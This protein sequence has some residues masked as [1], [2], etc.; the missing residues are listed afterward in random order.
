[1]RRL[2]QIS[3]SYFIRL[4]LLTLLAIAFDSQIS[5]GQSEMPEFTGERLTFSGVDSAAWQSLPPVIAELEQSGQ[6]TY[7][8]VVVESSGSGPTATKDYTDRLYEQWLQQAARNNVAFDTQR[9]VLVVLAI[10]NRQISVKAGQTLLQDYGLNGVVIDQ[11]LVQPYFISMAKAGNYPEGVKSL[12]K[13]LNRRIVARDQPSAPPTVV[14]QSLPVTITPPAPAALNA[15]PS[16]AA[17][18]EAQQ[19]TNESPPSFLRHAVTS[20]AYIAGT[21]IALGLLTLVILRIMHLQARKPLEVKRSNFRQH[22]VQLSDDIDLL[23]E[24]H[25]KLPFTDKDYTEPMIGETLS[26]YDGIQTSLETL[27]QRWLELMDVW[28]KIDALEKQEHFFGR[29]A[30]LEATKLLDTVPVGD[31]ENSLNEQCVKTLDRLEDAHEQ[32]Q[33]LDKSLD[34]DLVRIQE[35]L[36]ELQLVRL[37][38]EPYQ[39]SLEKVAELR[40]LAAKITVPDPIGSQTIQTNARET[41][42]SVGSLTERILQHRRGIDELHGKLNTVIVRLASLRNA[43]MKFCEEG[44][45]PSPLFPTIQHHCEECL[46]LLNLADANTAAEHLKQGFELAAQSQSAI[47]LQVDSQEFCRREIP[48][49]TNEQRQLESQL[50]TLDSIFPALE[51]EFAA[52]SWIGVANLQSTSSDA[53][54]LASTILTDATLAGSDSVQH[55][56]TAAAALRQL[57]QLQSDTSI[58]IAS[59]D[60][61]LQQLRKIRSDATVE[62]NQLQQYRAN[63]A[64]LLQSSTADREA[65]NHRFRD[66]ET[67]LQQL[68]QATAQSR[69][70]WPQIAESL[71]SIRDEISTSE[72]M[73][74]EDIRLAAKA[75]EE[76]TSAQRELRQAE[77]FY[78]SGFRADV[79]SVK[80]QL[81]AAQQALSNQNYERAIEMASAVIAGSRQ[82]IRD[83]EYAANERERRRERERRDRERS[84]G[85][86]LGIITTDF[87]SSSAAHHNFGNSSTFSMPDTSSHS[88]DT[89]TSSSS[90]SSETS[91]SSW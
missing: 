68:V 38:T 27:R 71:R 63:V 89:S 44:S 54:S 87:S 77:S 29:N 28:D 20:P 24:R 14:S 90:W 51:S 61:R 91:Q 76:I 1:M 75:A 33:R 85:A 50:K 58:N 26:M 42:R 16:V 32:V 18:T 79:S 47:Q 35:Q 8:V 39:P 31:V 2:S 9:S 43:G 22:V 6:E 3:D 40:A 83:A 70:D 74:K 62:L 36:T 67:S 17:T 4:L 46:K 80:P 41:L 60:Q 15:E 84:S 64:S 86:G 78:R 12:L 49:R 25:R 88:I 82:E 5:Y 13:Q 7:Y 55:Y 73:S 53:V 56:Q 65:A 59:G 69:A 72:Q 30:L 81:S 66:A 34:E 23:R 57:K 52:A 48:I 37:A 19:A 10:Q 11:Q 45:D 21:G